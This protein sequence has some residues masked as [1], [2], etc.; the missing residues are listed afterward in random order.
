[1]AESKEKTVKIRIRSATPGLAYAQGRWYEVSEAEFQRLK[2]YKYWP[3][4]QDPEKTAA[5]TLNIEEFGKE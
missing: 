5:Q 3:K 4:G 1:M 2:K